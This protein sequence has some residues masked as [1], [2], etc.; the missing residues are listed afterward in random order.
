[1][2]LDLF[3]RFLEPSDGRGASRWSPACFIVLFA[4]VKSW[5]EKKK[6]KMKEDNPHLQQKLRL[7]NKKSLVARQSKK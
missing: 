1:M 5:P 4:Q 6:M 3:T 7:R 2:I